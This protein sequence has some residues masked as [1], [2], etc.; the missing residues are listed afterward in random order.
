MA[1]IEIRDF[2]GRVAECIDC[3]FVYDAK[4]EDIEGGYWS[5]VYNKCL[6]WIL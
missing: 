2:E 4:Y 5:R 1:K 3:G 6:Q